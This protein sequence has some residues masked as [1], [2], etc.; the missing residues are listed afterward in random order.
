MGYNPFRDKRGRFARADGTNSAG[1][2]M[3]GYDIAT[4][5]LAIAEANGDQKKVNDI[6]EYIA[7]KYPDSELGVKI[8]SEGNTD[9][10]VK[11][12]S[13]EEHEE[14][15]Q[16]TFDT[17]RKLGN[18]NFED[19]FIYFESHADYEEPEH[20]E[21]DKDED[22]EDDWDNWDAE[23]GVYVAHKE[24]WECGIRDLVDGNYNL[25]QEAKEKLKLIAYSIENTSGNGILRSQRY[26]DE[27]DFKSDAWVTTYNTQRLA[28]LI[29]FERNSKYESPCVLYRNSDYEKF[30]K[31]KDMSES[32]QEEFDT[33]ILNFAMDDSEGIGDEKGGYGLE[34]LYDKFNTPGLDNRLFA[35]FD[36]QSADYFNYDYPKFRTT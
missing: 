32:E 9:V 27:D 19:E 5:D 13:K 12:H 31:S 1:E 23:P 35:D 4:E 29:N 15:V 34:E 33:F 24:T 18:D 25:N 2:K 7:V 30:I 8:L 26:E 17:I 20:D 36:A 16:K 22:D 14:F 10:F 3:T 28:V 21:F 11:E 6:K